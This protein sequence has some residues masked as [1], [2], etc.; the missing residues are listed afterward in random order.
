VS[1]RGA[2]GLARRVVARNAYVV[3]PIVVALALFIANVIVEPDFVARSN[4]PTVLAVMCPFV[5]TGMA[6]AVPV[7]SGNAGVDL[8]VGPFAGFAAVVIADVF[9]PHGFGSP[10]LLIPLVLVGGLVA[11]AANGILVAY[12]RLPAII[13]TLGTYLFYSGMASEVLPTPG[14][15]VPQWVIGINGSYGPVPGILVVFAG[16]AIGWTLLSKTAF[17]R[18][19]LFV[20]GDERAAYTAGID[21]S[22]VRLSAYA[23]SGMFA[24]LAG[25]FLLG[26]LQS[27]DATAGPPYTISAITAVALGGIG[28]GGGRGGLLGAAVG[29]AVL[30]LIQSLLTASGVSVYELDIANG[31]I[32]V[33]ALGLNGTLLRFRST[34]SGFDG[35]LPIPPTTAQAGS[36][37]T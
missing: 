37:A 9:V 6:E 12:V 5:L 8:S 10:E 30:Y 28:L 19:L 17:F 15:S 24:A 22:A 7:L 2:T 20:G 16:V 18:N 23:L 29:G 33:A 36:E 31:A 11:G 26:L 35:R 4:W 13:A 14:G 21:V 1:E 3:I 32:L 25:L 34:G 27:G